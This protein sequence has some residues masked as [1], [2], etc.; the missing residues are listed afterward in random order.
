MT[1]VQVLGLALQL[2]AGG[3]WNKVRGG[4]WV[5]WVLGVLIACIIAAAAAAG[6][7]AQRQQRFSVL[8]SWGTGVVCGGSCER[9]RQATSRDWQYGWQ[10][11]ALHVTRQHQGCSGPLYGTCAID[12]AAAAL[13]A[14]LLL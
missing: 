9:Q 7:P 11:L 14:D 13:Q 10:G 1:S 2:I 4:C 5:C 3:F 8:Q 6:L 12:A